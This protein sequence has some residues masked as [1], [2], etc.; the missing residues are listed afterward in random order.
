MLL[1]CFVDDNAEIH[2]LIH[3]FPSSSPFAFPDMVLCFTSLDSN[4][5]RHDRKL[6][7]ETEHVRNTLWMVSCKG[8]FPL[9]TFLVWKLSLSQP[10]IYILSFF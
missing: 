5:V 4:H 1:L 3:D 7:A 9:S 2:L 8:K 10:I 6:E